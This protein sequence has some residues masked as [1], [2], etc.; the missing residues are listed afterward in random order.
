MCS[1]QAHTLTTKKAHGNIKIQ[2]D[3]TYVKLSERIKLKGQIQ[4]K[5]QRSNMNQQ[6]KT[7]QIRTCKCLLTYNVNISYLQDRQLCH[8]D[9]ISFKN[10]KWS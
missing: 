7:A 2:L 3:F 9:L 10:F 4:F 6:T 8:T 1:S 5:S